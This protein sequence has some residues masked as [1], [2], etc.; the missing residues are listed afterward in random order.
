[1]FPP[2]MQIHSGVAVWKETMKHWFL[3]P[4]ECEHRSGGISWSGVEAAWNLGVR[5]LSQGK[6]FSHSVHLFSLWEKK[7][8]IALQMWQITNKQADKEQNNHN[9]IKSWEMLHLHRTEDGAM[10]I[11]N[12]EADTDLIHIE[13]K[14]KGFPCWS[15]LDKNVSHTPVVHEVNRTRM[16][17][18]L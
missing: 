17:R 14:Q 11:L 15:S 8:I 7:K 5:G 6:S 4:L 18:T 9:N 10:H 16:L 3:Y 1:M 13:D 2:C 12:V